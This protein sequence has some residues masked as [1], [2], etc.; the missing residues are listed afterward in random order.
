MTGWMSAARNDPP[1]A[2]RRRLPRALVVAAAVVS[3]AVAPVLLPAVAGADELS[4]TT[5]VGQLVQAWAEAAPG[6]AEDHAHEGPISW[7]QPAQGDPV[8]VETEGV[9]GV[10]AGSTVAVTVATTSEDRIGE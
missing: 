2:G 3:G 8:H 10:P 4:G 5:V 9:E 7:V 6:E 1:L